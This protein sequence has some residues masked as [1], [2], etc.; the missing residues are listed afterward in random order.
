MDILFSWIGLQDEKA[1]L[2]NNLGD[3]AL[4]SIL[5][6]KHYDKLELLI[7]YR[8]PNKSER[9]EA[10]TELSKLSQNCQMSLTVKLLL[11]ILRFQILPVFLKYILRHKLL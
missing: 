8:S 1:I 5:A 3:C 10:K 4:G 9:Q 7:D 6:H 11:I 2:G